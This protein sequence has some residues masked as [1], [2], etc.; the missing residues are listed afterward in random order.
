MKFAEFNLHIA[1]LRHFQSVLNGFRHIGKQGLHF[2][3]R[4]QVKLFL[5]VAHA[6]GVVEIALGANAD[7]AIV[8]MGITF[9]DVM[10]IVGCNQL[11]SEFLGPANEVVIDLGLFRDSV[12]LEFQ[13]KIFRSH[14]LFEPVQGIPGT[15]GVIIDD[16][17][18]NFA[19]QATGEGDETP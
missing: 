7:Q 13:I 2:L 11:Q 17:S 5:H 19:G 12:V 15:V 3:R 1:F 16:G 9:F 8:G 6:F 18:G 4:P 14:G 10:N